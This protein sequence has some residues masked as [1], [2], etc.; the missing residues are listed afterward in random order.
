MYPTSEEKCSLAEDPWS[1]SHL[2]PLYTTVFVKLCDWRRGTTD[3]DR[4]DRHAYI[5]IM[6]C[7]TLI[8][9]NGINHSGSP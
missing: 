6:C 1:V 8:A 4:P 2:V 5:T 7:I 9:E 3:I